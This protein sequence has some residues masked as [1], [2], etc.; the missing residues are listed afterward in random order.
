MSKPASTTQSSAQSTA[1]QNHRSNLSNPG[2]AAHKAAQDNRSNQL[3]PNNSK[4][5]N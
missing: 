1:A 2:S 3:N 5:K 4:T